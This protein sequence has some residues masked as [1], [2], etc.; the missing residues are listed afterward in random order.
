MASRSQILRRHLHNAVGIDVKGYLYLRY[1]GRRCLDS[2]QL[3]T[4]QQLII[5]GKL[6]LPLKDLDIHGGLEIGR[7]GKY[8]AVPGR[9]GRIPIDNLRGNAANISVTFDLASSSD[10]A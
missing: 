7:S 4:P 2:S 1:P 9:N 5:L 3:K 6:T 10:S 8:L